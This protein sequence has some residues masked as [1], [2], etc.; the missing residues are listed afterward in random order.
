[1]GCIL[2]TSYCRTPLLDNFLHIKIDSLE[3]LKVRGDNL[4]C[5]SRGELY[6]RV[7]YKGNSQC[8]NIKNVCDSD[9]IFDENLILVNSSPCKSGN[10]CITIELFDYDIITGN[11]LLG[12]CHITVPNKVNE[13]LIKK[14]Y[15]LIN[16]ES[17]LVG[18]IKISELHFIK[19][20]LNQYSG[21]LKGV[22]CLFCCQ[23][24]GKFVD[25]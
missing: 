23:Y 15:K 10:H 9:C 7:K 14:K 16:N 19:E 2:S 1:M 4:K 20:K 25:E 21:P 13:T 18:Y 6:I 5:H 3:Q 12:V 11:D 17:E 22:C 24:S 8:T